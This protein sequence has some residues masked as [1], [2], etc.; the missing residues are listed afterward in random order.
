[1][2]GSCSRS[3]FNFIRNCPTVFQH[4]QFYISTSSVRVSVA[5]HPHQYLLQII[6]LS[7]L[8]VILFCISLMISNVHVLMCL[9]FIH[10]SSL[11][12]WL[13]TVFWPFL[14]RLIIFFWQ[15]FESSLHVLDTNSLANMRFSTAFLCGLSFHSKFF[16]NF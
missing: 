14:I 4:V 11:L 16:I 6:Y 15:S 3:R 12:K 1:M 13:F 10:I 5:P 7:I 8:N 2:T 9:F